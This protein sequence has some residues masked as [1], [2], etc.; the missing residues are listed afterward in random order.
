MIG[1]A[2]T[3]LRR[4][5]TFFLRRFGQEVCERH[6]EAIAFIHPQHNRARALVRPQHCISGRRCGTECRIERHHIAP[7]GEKHASRNE[8]RKSVEQISLFKRNDIGFHGAGA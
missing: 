4:N 7:K 5:S 8:G 6:F 1:Q 3:V 2:S